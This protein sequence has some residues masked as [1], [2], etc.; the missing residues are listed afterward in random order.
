MSQI[1]HEKAKPEDSAPMSKME[2]ISIFASAMRGLVS[3]WKLKSDLQEQQEKLL[4]EIMRNSSS[5]FHFLR[6]LLVLR[7][8]L[9][10]GGWMPLMKLTAPLVKVTTRAL[11]QWVTNYKPVKD[12]PFVVVQALEDQGI[13]TTAARNLEIVRGT[14]Q[15][16]MRGLT[17]A[18]AIAE[19]KALALVHVP[20]PPA[21]HLLTAREQ[22]V[23]DYRMAG[24]PALAKIAENQKAE[25][26]AQSAA[27]EIWLMTGRR[28]PITITPTE[29]VV[30][31]SSR[32]KE[33]E[34]ETAPTV[35]Y[36]LS[37]Q[38]LVSLANARAA[39]DQMLEG[40]MA[41]VM[42]QFA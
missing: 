40:F 32:R 28:E 34:H 26:I 22:W 7:S 36:G 12:T 4:D 39:F 30:D 9:K 37:A 21:V 2:E 25:V 20:P 16:V 33:S 15:A 19:A 38:E 5:R 41:A 42:E 35:R 3:Q 13:E 10:H 18:E 17:T 23:H 27:E 24:R 6:A 1:D 31:L 14:H 11:G 8:G 29:P